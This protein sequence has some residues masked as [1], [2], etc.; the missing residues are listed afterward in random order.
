M[1][2]SFADLVGFT[3]MGEEVPPDELGRMATRLEELTADTLQ[4]P[5]RLVKTIGDAAMLVSTDTERLLDSSLALVEAADA[6]G[7]SFPQLRVGVARGPAQ[8]R[9]GDWFGRPV[10]MAS[11]ITNVARPGSVLA[12]RDVRDAVGDGYRWSFAGERR[13]KGIREPVPLFR[14]RRDGREE[15]AGRR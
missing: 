14:A 15:H 5:A 7:E 11:R 3:R 8:S 12:S 4:A 6:E 13:L 1:A 2:V 10:N 9:A